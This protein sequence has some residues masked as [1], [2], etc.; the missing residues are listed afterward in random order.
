[1]WSMKTW[2]QWEDSHVNEDGDTSQEM[3]GATTQNWKRQ[4]NIFLENQGEYVTL[5]NVISDFQ[6]P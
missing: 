5:K 2:T 6:P 1:M 3:P 4:R